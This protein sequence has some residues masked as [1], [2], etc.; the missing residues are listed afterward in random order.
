MPNLGGVFL[1][2][3]ITGGI[4]CMAVQGGLLATYVASRRVEDPKTRLPDGQGGRVEVKEVL[5]F[6]AAKLVA[7]TLL[8]AGLG[9]LGAVLQ[10]TPVSRA[11]FQ[12]VVA[13]YMVGVGLAML[14]VH[15][16][17]R[18]FLVSTPRF[19]GRWIRQQSKSERFFMPAVLGAA[20]VFIPCGTTQAMMALALATGKPVWGAAVLGVFVIGTSPL[21]MVLGL[22]VAK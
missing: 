6:L 5:A 10:M 13:A 12:G 8:G 3:L 19:L 18:R 16:F 20:T 2:G 9:W 17:F 15:P 22:A 4:T 21:F 1:T 7:Y 14:E 11:I